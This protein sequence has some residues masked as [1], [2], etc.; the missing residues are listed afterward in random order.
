MAKTSIRAL[1]ILN[2][3]LI[4]AIVAE[5]VGAAEEAP[6]V[7]RASVAVRPKVGGFFPLGGDWDDLFK[8]HAQFEVGMKGTFD[9]FGLEIALGTIRDTED[10][11][12]RVLVPD[13]GGE[14]GDTILTDALLEVRGRIQAVKVTATFELNPLAGTLGHEKEFNGYVGIGGGYY[15]TTVKIRTSEDVSQAI[16]ELQL[17]KGKAD[18]TGY[19]PHAVI[20]GEYFIDR[21]FGLFVEAQYS[22]ILLDAND[23][24]EDLDVHG[25]S[26]LGGFSL[27][28]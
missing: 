15:P 22:Y 25:V 18:F 9:H 28:F 13:P 27:K 8:E 16:P 5:T 17:P 19:G 2:A 3:L 4:G 7:R 26:V 14:P 12:S 1:T 20:G 21:V 10:I 24:R 23:T 6:S 11:V